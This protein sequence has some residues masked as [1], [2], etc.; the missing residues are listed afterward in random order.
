MPISVQF[1]VSLARHQQYP[2]K[3]VDLL[4]TG[5]RLEEAIC[6][7]ITSPICV[8]DSFN[9]AFRSRYSNQEALASQQA[10]TELRFALASICATTFST[11]RVHSKNLRQKLSRVMTRIA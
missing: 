1:L 7:F 8:L 4:Q 3:L 9:L 5:W 11:E 2:F 10:Q 6:E